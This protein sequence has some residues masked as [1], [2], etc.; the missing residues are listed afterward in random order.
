MRSGL[1]L[2]TVGILVQV[3]VRAIDESTGKKIFDIIYPKKRHALHKRDAEEDHGPLKQEKYEDRLQYEIDLKGKTMVLH[4]EKNKELLSPD[5]VEVQYSP[6]GEAVTT[7]PQIMENCYYQGQ[8]LNEEMSTASISTCQGL[9]GFFEHQDQRYFIEPL[10]L[11]QQEEQEHALYTYESQEQ[12]FPETS[13]GVDLVEEGEPLLEKTVRSGSNGMEREDKNEKKYIEYYLVLD[14]KMFRKYNRNPEEIRQRVFEMVNFVNMLYKKLGMQ[15]ALVGLEIWTNG[16]QIKISPNANVTLENF[17]N[18]RGGI[19]PQMKRHD[20]AQ[21]ITGTDL[22]G[23]IVGLAFMSTMC[24]PYHS[25]G[26]V[27][28]HSY[29]LLRVAGTMAH[30]MGHNF[31]MY[32]DSYVC[33]CPSSICVMDPAL[34]FYIPKDFSSCSRNSFE[35]FLKIVS[36]KCLKNVPLPN[37]IISTPIC[38]NLLVELGEECDC[39]SPEECTNVCCDATTCKIKPNFKCA[40]GECCENCQ[41]KKA[42]T[43]CRPTKDECDLPEMCDGKSGSCPRDRFRVNGFPCQNGQGYCLMGQC[44]TLQ[45]QCVSL[46]GEGAQAAEKSCFDINSVGLTYG[47]CR[48]VDDMHIPCKAGS[49]ICGKLYC[50]GGS[51][52]LPWKGKI[53]S[54]LT[55][56][57]FSS[58]DNQ[59]ISM[60][61]NGTKCGNNSVCINGDCI[62]IENAYKSSNCSS[63][64]KGHAVCDHE[65]QCQC[66][67]GW[68]PPNCDNSTIVFHFSIVMGILVALSIIIIIAAII[69]RHQ[70]R[71][72]RKKVQSQSCPT[73]GSKPKQWKP[74]KKHQ[75]V[76]STHSHE[77]GSMS[78]PVS[79]P[80]TE[81]K[82]PLPLLITKPALPPSMILTTRSSFVPPI[83][84]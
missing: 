28:D 52:V 59:D 8:V 58:D 55:C 1:L 44:P 31:G 33:K 66:E 19:L 40:F 47:Y 25:V 77:M 73:S 48:K 70:S 63:K 9:R 69:L 42:G 60:V 12:N 45:D 36:P 29:D 80:Q 82:P 53:M 32:H 79:I 39:G 46:W 62:D 54:F 14:N 26:I 65:L 6:T 11:A 74:M 4:L 50:Y 27:Q 75:D 17:S 35:K 34:S 18:W 13:C 68:L 81:R 61:A 38:G 57:T 24:S 37:D 41:I 49:S 5:Y 72:K 3:P 10:G 2:A 64:C 71:A 21:L 15:V 30:E 83:S 22:T 16:N 76:P 20:I 67:E 7:S 23:P 84:N 56:K 43:L 78:L 51:D